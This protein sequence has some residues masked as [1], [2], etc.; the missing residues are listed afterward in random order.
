MTTQFEELWD[1]PMS[2][3]GFMSFGYHNEDVRLHGL[4]HNTCTMVSQTDVP[5]LGTVA[6][7]HL[8]GGTHWT[9]RGMPR[10]YDG[11][12]LQTVLMQKN[13]HSDHPNAAQFRYVVISAPI[14]ASTSAEERKCL[15]ILNAQKEVLS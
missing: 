4:D 15:T 13:N 1:A 9:G 8:K 10:S 12:E 3:R 6:V 11:A 2:R 14:P 5:G 7:L